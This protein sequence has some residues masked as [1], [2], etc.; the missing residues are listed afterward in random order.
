MANDF[1]P[2]I[3]G[4]CQANCRFITHYIGIHGTSVPMC[5][6]A[7]HCKDSASIAASL[8]TL[9]KSYSTPR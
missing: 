4:A 5:T 3:N 6:L 8:H 7:E 2:F 1:C 9:T